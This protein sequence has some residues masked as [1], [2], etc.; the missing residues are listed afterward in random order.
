ML[1]KH[2][3]PGF[4]SL[5]GLLLC[6]V[7]AMA[8]SSCEKGEEPVKPPLGVT[9]DSWPSNDE[10]S[11]R[12]LSKGS[13]TT[14]APTALVCPADAVCGPMDVV[15]IIDTTGSMLGAIDNVNSE[16]TTILSCIETVSGGDYRLALVTFAD[17]ITVLHNFAATNAA[18][19]GTSIAG[20]T[21]WAGAG[22]AEASDEALNTVV[23]ALPAAGRA[24]NV[25]FTPDWRGAGVAKIVILVTDAP[26]GGFDDTYT[27]GVDDVNAHA[28]ALEAFG[29]G[30]KI[31]A[32]FVP[33][34]GDYAGQAAIMN[35]YATTT[36][37]V[38]VLANSDGSGTGQ[39][40]LDIISTCGSAQIDVPLDIKPGSCPN[41]MNVADK[42]VLP[43][44]ILGTGDFDVNDIDVS[45]VTLEGVA[46]VQ[47]AFGDVAEPYAGDL[48]D[49]LSCWTNGPDGYADLTLKFPV[50]A[51][52]AALGE[53]TDGECLV[54]TL[55]GQTTDDI[56]ISGTDIVKII[57]KPKPQPTGS[58]G[59]TGDN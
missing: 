18:A 17:T 41:P 19:V 55:T 47:Y 10:V 43:V 5:A 7:L 31:S 15:F 35:D 50:Q 6:V 32:I 48:N 23:N 58:V 16:L 53:V 3:P 4:L 29:K 22:A 26:P 57:K 8:V 38:Y 24:Q 36:N 59:G 45:T 21:A 46:P 9:N 51:V 27:A 40:I 28:R 13:P 11:A 44:A 37:G 2:I 56:L 42:G 20:L 52:L 12:I 54:L 34:S 33:T 39:G 14:K 25:D 1:Y 49:C 30:I